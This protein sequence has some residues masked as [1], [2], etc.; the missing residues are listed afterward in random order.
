MLYMPYFKAYYIEIFKN[1]CRKSSCHE[2]TLHHNDYDHLVQ[3]S[4]H[5]NRCSLV[6]FQSQLHDRLAKYRPLLGGYRNRIDMH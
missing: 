6:P 2:D 3:L 1:N 5:D 4:F